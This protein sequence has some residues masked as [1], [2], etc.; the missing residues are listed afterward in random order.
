MATATRGH[1]PVS[2]ALNEAPSGLLHLKAA[3]T[4]GMGFVT[5][6]YDLQIIGLA[7]VLI[8]PQF[9]LSSTQVG[10]LSSTALIASFIGAIVF[11]RISDLLG[12]KRIYGLEAAIMA[13]GAILTAFAPNFG[14]LLVTRFILGIGIGGDYPTSAVLMTEWANKRNRGRQV[15]IMFAGYTGGQLLGLIVAMTLLASGIPHELA[16]RLMLGLGAL[17]ALAVLNSRRRMPESPRYVSRVRGDT[18]KAAADLAAYSDGSVTATVTGPTPGGT[19]TVLRFLRTRGYLLALLGTA[20]GWFFADISSYGNS[21]SAPLIIKGLAPHAQLV[22]VPSITF[23]IAVLA[24]L[25]GLILTI[26]LID[27]IGHKRIQ[28]ASLGLAGLMLILVGVIPGVTGSVGPFAVLYGAASFFGA[29][30]GVTTMVFAA[31]VFPAAARGTGHGL[32]AGMAKFG[33]YMGAL[34]APLLLAGIGLAHTELIAGIV[35]LGGAVCTLALPEPSGRSLED[36]GREDE[37][38]AQRGGTPEPVASPTA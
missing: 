17:P 16:W 2:D 4:A 33:A 18:K 32:S 10:L 3:L 5:D 7:L 37:L 34:A 6:A 27:R 36:L 24:A 30:W 21:L 11:G 31:E 19:M 38:A 13:V 25:P 9:N 20:G 8:K 28:L 1:D 14:W 12:R 26:Y 23:M 22:T 29:G 35:Y 15:G